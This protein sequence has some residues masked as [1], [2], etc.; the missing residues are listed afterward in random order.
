VAKTLRFRDIFRRPRRID[1]S[2]DRNEM[3]SDKSP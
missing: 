2:H 3:H 1:L